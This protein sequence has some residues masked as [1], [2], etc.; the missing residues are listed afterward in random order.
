MGP[1]R[2]IL[3]ILSSGA[4]ETPALHRACALAKASGAQLQ[5]HLYAHH[6]LIDALGHVS[7]NVAGM[8]QATVLAQY[9]DWLEETVFEL[10]ECGLTVSGQVYWEHA[11]AES[12]L[13]RALD[14]AP[15]L[16]IKDAG[17]AT[18][19]RA[20]LPLSVDHEL[21]RL[22]PFP[23]YLVHGGGEDLPKK[24]VVAVDPAHPWHCDGAL[25]ER[26]IFAA[27]DYALQ[28]D[29]SM[30]LLSVCSA[31]TDRN[32]HNNDEYE[33][34]RL[35]HKMGLAMLVK[36]FGVA[37]Q[38]IHV[39]HG[40]AVS[41][42]AREVR[43]SGAGLLVIGSLCRSGIGR[44]VAG[45]V[46]ARLVDEI[47]CDLLAVKPAGFDAVFASLFGAATPNAALMR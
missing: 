4:E 32:V 1:Y 27:R 8:A 30:E 10:H 21:L 5:I 20:V 45:S 40:E 7:K 37:A 14:W 9:R 13:N 12:I 35:A 28:A 2:R 25:N 11:D 44:L 22:C 38:H 17:R 34:Q 3:L 24:I 41:T 18:A 15:D 23:L 16:L 42:L 39:H 26:I 33:Q 43:A 29:A 36:K 46:A 31:D 47:D 19:L 6:R